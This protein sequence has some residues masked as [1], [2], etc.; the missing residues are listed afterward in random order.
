MSHYGRRVVLISQVPCILALEYSHCIL[1]FEV[2]AVVVLHGLTFYLYFSFEKNL[3]KKK[4]K[5]KANDRKVKD[6][7]KRGKD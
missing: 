2:N 1:W 4:R 3:Q 6:E 7:Q 5:K